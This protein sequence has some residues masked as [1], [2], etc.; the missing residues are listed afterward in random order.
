MA[1]RKPSI[2]T[3]SEVFEDPK[4]ARRVFEMSRRE[5]V[6]F[7]KAAHELSLLTY[8]PFKTWELRLTALSELD[9]GL[10]GQEAIQNKNG[11]WLDYINSGDCYNPTIVYWRGKYRVCCVADIV[12][13]PRN[14]F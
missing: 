6:E 4:Q 2:K 13:N 10:C 1:F 7:S 11:E 8:H 9:N 3:L 5:L 14:K 12:E